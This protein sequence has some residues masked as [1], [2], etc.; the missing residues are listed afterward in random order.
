MFDVLKKI[1]KHECETDVLDAEIY[2]KL[3]EA[4]VIVDNKYDN[5]CI[6]DQK[7]IKYSAAAIKSSNT[8]CFLN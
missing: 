7:L 8:F 3:I 5:N 1:E 2:Q 4:K 6:L